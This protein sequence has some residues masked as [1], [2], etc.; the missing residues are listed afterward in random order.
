MVKRIRGAGGEAVV[1]SFTILS[2]NLLGVFEEKAENP[3]VVGN[4]NGVHLSTQ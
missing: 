2:R 1:V 4:S 3:R